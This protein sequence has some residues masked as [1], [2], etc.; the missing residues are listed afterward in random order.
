MVNPFLNSNSWVVLDN[1]IVMDI[2]QPGSMASKVEAVG[3]SFN[4]STCSRLFWK[5]ND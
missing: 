4:Y 5:M 3:G 1:I 2:Q